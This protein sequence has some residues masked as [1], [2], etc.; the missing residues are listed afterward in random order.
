[1]ECPQKLGGADQ[2]S[3]NQKEAFATSRFCRVTDQ[4]EAA[5]DLRSSITNMV[6]EALVNLFV[7]RFT[8]YPLQRPSEGHW[9]LS[10]S[11]L[12]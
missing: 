12:T 4:R 1:M 7:Q 5:T 8:Q 6:C 10:V 3:R 11:K 9:W 2:S